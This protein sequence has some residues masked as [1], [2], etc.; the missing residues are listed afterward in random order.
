MNKRSNTFLGIILSAGLFLGF[1][2]CKVH[3]EQKVSLKN[4]TLDTTK[5]KTEYAVG[6]TFTTDGLVVTATYSNKTSKGVTGWTASGND[7]SKVSE[8]QTI[9]ISYT[10]DK[11]TVTATYTIAIK[12]KYELKYETQFGSVPPVKILDGYKLTAADL[13]TLTQTGYV[14][15][16]WSKKAGD[17]INADTTITAIWTPATNTAYKVEHYQQN[18]ADDDY[19]IVS[20]DTE[21]KTGTT[22]ADTAATAKTYTGFTA[23]EIKQEKIAADGTT[24]VKVYYDRINYTIKFNTDGGSAIDDITLKYGATV[25][26]PANP[27]RTGYVFE[28]WDGTIPTTIPAENL[29]FTASWKKVDS[30]FDI[31]LDSGSTLKMDFTVISKNQIKFEVPDGYDSYMWLVDGTKDTSITTNQYSVTTST[32]TDGKHEILVIVT[33][34]DGSKNSA[35]ATFVVQN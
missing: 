25:T 2:G 35:R 17:I 9:T 20:V 12:E 5:V 33:A 23:K 19:V 32:Y 1:S 29:T 15:N 30:S 34:A 4:I 3:V 18:I 21:N 11:K 24:V 6:D 10:E 27:T 14:F 8:S 28:K 13:P 31:T 16:G 7:L 22:L 26:A